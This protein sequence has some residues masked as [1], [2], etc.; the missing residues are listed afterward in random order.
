MSHAFQSFLQQKGIPSQCS[1]PYTP[2]QNGVAERKN[3]HLLDVVESSVSPRFWVEALS[4]AVYLINCMPSPTL[5]LDSPYSCLFGVPPDYNSLLV[6]GCVCFVHLPPIERHKLAAQSV[7]C[8]FLGYSNSHKGFVCYDADANKLRISRNGTFFEN[9]YFF[10]P[11][12][13]LG[14]SFISL[15]AFDDVSS[16][17]CCKPYIVYQ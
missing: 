6:F 7:Q 15:H 14:S 4:T 1:C 17:P 3:R 5:D 12:T 16:T 11:R 2:R 8:A 10:P 9:Q 13:N